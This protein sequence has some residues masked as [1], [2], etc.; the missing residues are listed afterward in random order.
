M[1]EPPCACVSLRVGLQ[2]SQCLLCNWN[3]CVGVTGRNKRQSDQQP[4]KQASTQFDAS[5]HTRSNPKHNPAAYSSNEDCDRQNGSSS[6]LL[7]GSPRGRGE[8][9]ADLWDSAG[10]LGSFLSAAA[11]PKRP[12][13]DPSPCVCG[14]C[15]VFV[16]FFFFVGEGRVVIGCPLEGNGQNYMQGLPRKRLASAYLQSRPQHPTFGGRVCVC[17]S[18]PDVVMSGSLG[19]HGTVGVSLGGALRR[20]LISISTPNECLERWAHTPQRAASPYLSPLC[21][22]QANQCI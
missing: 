19:K 14:L 2:L 22:V 8:D 15:F 18:F 17:F 10:G 3:R 12:G 21:V 4:H 5:Q 6:D 7:R 9:D 13:R 16:L 1:A 20:Q 11:C